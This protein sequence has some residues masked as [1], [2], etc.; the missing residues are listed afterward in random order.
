MPVLGTH[1]GAVYRRARRSSTS[2]RSAPVFLAK[3]SASASPA[4]EGATARRDAREVGAGEHHLWLT[5]S[6]TR[7]CLRM[8]QHGRVGVA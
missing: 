5:A 2:S 1:E 6:G 4:H 3:V 8:R 7:S